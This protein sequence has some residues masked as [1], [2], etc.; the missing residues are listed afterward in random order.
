M[1]RVPVGL[2]GACGAGELLTSWSDGPGLSLTRADRR[3]LTDSVAQRLLAEIKRQGLREGTRMPSE[4]RLQESLGVSRS[5]VRE[6]LRGTR[7]V[8]RDLAL[9]DA[10]RW[11]QQG[12]AGGAVMADR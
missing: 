1:M 8:D 3:K 10:L 12:P 6:A 11:E 4:R 2:A 5:T 7:R 9:A